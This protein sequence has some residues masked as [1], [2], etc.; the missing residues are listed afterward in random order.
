[1]N[2]DVFVN[3]MN[4][5]AE[6]MVLCNTNALAAC[7]SE[8]GCTNLQIYVQ[9]ILHIAEPCILKMLVSCSFNKI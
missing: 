9:I 6:H 2:P 1:M 8:K 7:S 4:R 5:S 3:N